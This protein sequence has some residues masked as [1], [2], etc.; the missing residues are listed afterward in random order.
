MPKNKNKTDS[1]SSATKNTFNPPGKPAPAGRK[2]PETA[3]RQVGE[4]TGRGVPAL[5]KK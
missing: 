4:Y 3:E 5:E 2:Q 1:K